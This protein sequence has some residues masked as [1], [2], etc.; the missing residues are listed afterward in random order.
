MIFCTIKD[1]HTQGTKDNRQIENI[2]STLCSSH[3][4]VIAAWLFGSRA[5][6]ISSQTGDVDIAVLLEY[7]KSDSFSLLFFISELEKSIGCP[8]DVVILNHAG[9]KL[10]FEVRRYGRLVFDRKPVFRKKFEVKRRKTYEDFLYLHN[11]YVKTVLYG[12][13]NG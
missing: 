4:A 13:R 8:V 9:D 11:R 10:S 5:K 12:E 7:S 3:S 6:D 2:V 1:M